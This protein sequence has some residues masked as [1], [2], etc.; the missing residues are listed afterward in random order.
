MLAKIRAVQGDVGFYYKNLV[1][2]DAQAFEPEK[3]LV[4]ASVI[5][6]P[7]MIEAFRQ[8]DA[9]ELDPNAPVKVRAEDRVPSCGVLTYLHDGVTVTVRDLVTLMIIV[10]D[11]MAT[12]LLMDRIGID[13][14]NRTL[15][16]LGAKKTRLRRKMF[17]MESA[18]RGIQNTVTAGEIGKLLEKL[19][20]GDVV[21]PAASEEMVAILKN[22]QLNGKMPFRVAD[23]IAIAHKTGED[24]GV[25]HDVGVV[26]APEPFVICFLS[27]HVDVPAFNRLIQDMTWEFAYA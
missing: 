4:A 11:N 15:D 7:M 18:A 12:N 24:S 21:S 3:P 27:N 25:T 1:T 23:D 6:L 26:Y 13:N 20:W 10:S 8:F 19:Y 5:K 9:G 22:Q 16:S 17:D 14:V 2:G